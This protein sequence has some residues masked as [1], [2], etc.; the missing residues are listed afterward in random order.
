MSRALATAGLAPSDVDYVNVHGTS[1]GVNDRVETEAIKNVFGAAAAHLAVSSTK[2]AVGHLQG[3]A[4]AAEAIATLLLL[5]Q[6][7]A[8]P[9]LGLENPDDGMDLNYVALEAQ[10]LSRAE[11]G[12]LLIALSNSFG[13]GGHNV[14]I[15]L[16]SR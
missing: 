7:V 3:A 14:T 2:S 6:G 9:T 16:R 10:S 8:G 5:G 11:S 4:G 15:A 1:T 12:A 13:F